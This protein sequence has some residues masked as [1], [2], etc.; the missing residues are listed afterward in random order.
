[1]GGLNVLLKR[2]WEAVTGLSEESH[3]TCWFLF[4]LKIFLFINSAAGQS[5][6]PDYSS[7]I[8]AL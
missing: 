3:R 4:N 5:I 1:M 6:S 8:L 2:W 7:G